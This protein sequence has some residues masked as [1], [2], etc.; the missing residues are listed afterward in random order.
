MDSLNCFLWR[1][2]KDRYLSGFRVNGKNGEGMKVSHMLFSNDT[3]VFYEAT[4]AQITYLSLLPLWFESI[5]YFRINLIKS[6]LILT[7]KVKNLKD[8]ALKLG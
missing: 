8:L 1:A 2:G 4:Q 6:R 3:L 7:R 5:L